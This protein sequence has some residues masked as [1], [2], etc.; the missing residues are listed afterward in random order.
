[1]PSYIVRNARF[2]IKGEDGQTPTARGGET[3]Q[4]TITANNELEARTQG[5]A[6][7]GLPWQHVNVY[8]TSSRSWVRTKP[9]ATPG[10]VGIATVTGV[11]K[12]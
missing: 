8:E 4:V 1:M 12:S 7:L 10:E 11:K 3:V 6:M 2:D 9:G 5:A